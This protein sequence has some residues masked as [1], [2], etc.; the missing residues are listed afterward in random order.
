M[1]AYKKNNS[2]NSVSFVN[3]KTKKDDDIIPK[4]IYYLI[5]K[6][7]KDGLRKVL[8]YDY[9]HLYKNDDNKMSGIAKYVSKL[10]NYIL[11]L[12]S[13]IFLILGAI[14]IAGGIMFLISVALEIIGKSTKQREWSVFFISIILGIFCLS[15]SIGINIVVRLLNHDIYTIKKKKIEKIIKDKIKTYDK[16]ISKIVL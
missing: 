16:E 3:K 6:D 15:S 12:L 13:I 4:Y 11:I 14:S 9:W 8:I 1:K 7:D 2:I 5:D 10:C